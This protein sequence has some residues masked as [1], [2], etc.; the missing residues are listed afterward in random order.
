M[1]EKYSKKYKKA[2]NAFREIKNHIVAD[3][4]FLLY[5][6]IRSFPLY[7]SGTGNTALAHTMLYIRVAQSW[8]V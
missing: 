1:E 5:I 4:K 3:S 2:Q 6:V 8:Q 7:K